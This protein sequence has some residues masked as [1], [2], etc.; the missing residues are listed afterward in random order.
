MPA[1]CTSI[2]SVCRQRTIGVTAVPRPAVPVVNSHPRSTWSV[3]R[4]GVRLDVPAALA[5]TST[6]DGWPPL[7][8]ADQLRA[9]SISGGPANDA[10]T[11]RVAVNDLL[12]PPRNSPV[13]P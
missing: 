4:P 1:G 9:G 13:G 5:E 10:N 12:E 11:Q 8:P 2:S 3:W 6:V 7:V